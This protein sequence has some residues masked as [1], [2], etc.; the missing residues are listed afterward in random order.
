MCDRCR[1]FDVKNA[2]VPTEKKVAAT[3]VNKIMD[4][5]FEQMEEA[6][7]GESSIFTSPY[8]QDPKNLI[9]KNLSGAEVWVIITRLFSPIQYKDVVFIY[10]DTYKMATNIRGSNGERNGRRHAFWQISLVQRF[11]REF[12]E[13]LG[14]AHERGR[15]G[16]NLDNNVDEKNNE[17]ARKY[18]EQ[19]PGV[20]PYLGN[21]EMWEKGLLLDYNDEDPTTDKEIPN[22]TCDIKDKL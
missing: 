17:A 9:I 18:A 19:H 8:S 7:N 3:S 2:S 22:G 5:I 15:P 16:T 13:E 11:G 14:K 20:D 21:I 4:I 6:D 12:A 10:Y 1:L